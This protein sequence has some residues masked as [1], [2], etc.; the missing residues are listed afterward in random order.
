MMAGA[1][2]ERRVFQ[3]A[4]GPV[5]A[6]PINDTEWLGVDAKGNYH[7][8]YMLDPAQTAEKVAA[9][10]REES[11]HDVREVCSPDL[12]WKK[13]AIIPI[14]KYLAN[15]ENFQDPE[16]S[17]HFLRRNPQYLCHKDRRGISRF[18][19]AGKEARGN[20]TIR[21]EKTGT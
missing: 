3:T 21:S 13:R 16:F 7:F 12:T 4:N 1:E 8:F 14:D 15:M 17:D 20:G 10:L 2:S 9:R 11:R 18:S 6:G 19:H 5:V